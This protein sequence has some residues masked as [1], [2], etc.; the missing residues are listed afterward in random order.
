MLV[1]FNLFKLWL[2]NE[3]FIGVKIYISIV[4]GGGWEFYVS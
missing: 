1:I 2:R 4:M 3:V